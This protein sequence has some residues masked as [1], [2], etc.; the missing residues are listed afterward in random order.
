MAAFRRTVRAL[1]PVLAAAVLVGACSGGSDGGSADGG[2]N[3]ATTAIATAGVSNDVDGASNSSP[4]DSDPPP[5]T[6]DA[7]QL[8]RA[9]IDEFR[10]RV[11]RLPVAE[12]LAQLPVGS[13]VAYIG[14]GLNLCDEVGN[15]VDEAARSIGMSVERMD[16]DGTAQSV[17]DAW[18]RVAANPPDALIAGPAAAADYGDH[19]ATL[20][21]AGT[22]VVTWWDEEGYLPSS[23]IDANIVTGDDLFFS[24]V[25]MADYI[26]ATVGDAPGTV[27][28]VGYDGLPATQLVVDG[29]S[30]EIA[31]VC[32]QCVIQ[33][34]SVSIA[35]LN[36][37]A[38]GQQIADQAKAVG[39]TWIAFAVGDLAAGVSE[40]LG[41]EGDTPTLAVAQGG[42]SANLELLAAGLANLQAEI[43]I[44]GPHLG[45]RAVDVTARLLAGSS[46]GE[47][48]GKPLAVISGRPDI[49]RGGLPMGILEDGNLDDPSEPWPGVDDFRDLYAELWGI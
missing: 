23:G 30:G 20:K 34:M 40:G 41:D 5:D 18:A 17:S 11:P 29:F 1:A 35:D 49:L 14:C 9:R 38:S 26:G 39:A 33:S 45:Y 22:V 42:S 28:L 15:G 47:A 43:A 6:G 19:L 48:Q 3:P 7:K 13:R 25:L 12:P 2:N 31:S 46:P 27:L 8:G 36:S 32:Q 21:D 4:G 37:G 16:S 10:R 24:G 44:P